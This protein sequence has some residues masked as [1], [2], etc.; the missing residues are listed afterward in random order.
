MQG[1]DEFVRAYDEFEAACAEE[2]AVRA[3]SQRVGNLAGHVTGAANKH[4]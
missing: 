2:S 4:E 3:R 1:G